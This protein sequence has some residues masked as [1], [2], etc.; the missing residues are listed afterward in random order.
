V[1]REYSRGGFVRVFTLDEVIDSTNITAKYEAGVLLVTLPVIAGSAPS[2][3]KITV[4]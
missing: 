2:E 4:S 1:H 3:Q